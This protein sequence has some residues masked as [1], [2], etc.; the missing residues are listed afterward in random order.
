M[1][2]FRALSHADMATASCAAYAAARDVDRA[3][4]ADALACALGC[5]AASPS[6]RAPSEKARAAAVR[7]PRAGL[8]AVLGSAAAFSS[9][10]SIPAAGAGARAAELLQSWGLAPLGGGEHTS[11]ALLCASAVALASTVADGGVARARAVWELAGA[12]LP[13]HLG[14]WARGALTLSDGGADRRALSTLFTAGG[15]PSAITRYLH[16]L[17]QRAAESA[18]AP[19]ATLVDALNRATP[20]VHAAAEES[21]R[22]DSRALAAVAHALCVRADVICSSKT[23]SELTAMLPA[24][25]SV[26]ISD[27]CAGH[28]TAIV[29]SITDAFSEAPRNAQLNGIAQALSALSGWADGFTIV[30]ALGTNTFPAAPRTPSSIAH[31]IAAAGPL[32]W[33]LSVD[34]KPPNPRLLAPAG[35]A[36]R[37]DTELGA[38]VAVERAVAEALDALGACSSD[39]VARAAVCELLAPILRSLMGERL[40]SDE[41]ILGL[42]TGG[43]RLTVDGPTD[44]GSADEYDSPPPL[45]HALRTAVGMGPLPGAALLREPLGRIAQHIAI[46]PEILPGAPVEKWLEKLSAALSASTLAARLRA[47]AM[48]ERAAFLTANAPQYRANSYEDALRSCIIEVAR[49]TIQRCEFNFLSQS[50]LRPPNFDELTAAAA[51]AAPIKRMLDVLSSRGRVRVDGDDDASRAIRAFQT[52]LKEAVTHKGTAASFAHALRVILRE[53]GLATKGDEAEAVF[54]AIAA[55]LDVSKVPPTFLRSLKLEA[56]DFDFSSES[57]RGRLISRALEVDAVMGTPVLLLCLALPFATLSVLVARAIQDVAPTLAP[58]PLSS[59]SIFAPPPRLSFTPTVALSEWGSLAS[60]RGVGAVLEADGA[61]RVSSILDASAITV[62]VSADGSG[63]GMLVPPLEYELGSTLAIEL[64]PS[65]ERV[66]R[67]MVKAA[68]EMSSNV[69]H[70]CTALLDLALLTGGPIATLAIL[71]SEAHSTPFASLAARANFAMPP[72]LA[73]GRRAEVLRLITAA[74]ERVEKSSA[75]PSISAGWRALAI[76]LHLLPASEL[77][78]D[79]VRGRLPIADKAGRAAA[80]GAA[81]ALINWPWTANPPPPVLISLLCC[82]APL[83]VPSLLRARTRTVPSIFVDTL[84]R[85][86]HSQASSPFVPFTASLDFAVA[87]LALAGDGN[88]A[89]VLV[90]ARL[91]NSALLAGG[92]PEILLELAAGSGGSST[93]IALRETAQR[94]VT[95]YAQWSTVRDFLRESVRENSGRARGSG[96][97]TAG[98]EQAGRIALAALKAADAQLVEV[99]DYAEN[100]AALAEKTLADHANHAH[101]LDAD[102]PAATAVRS[103]APSPVGGWDTWVAD[104]GD[105]EQQGSSVE[106]ARA[107][108][109]ERIES[110]GGLGVMGGGGAATASGGLFAFATSALGSIAR[111]ASDPS[112][113]GAVARRAAEFVSSAAESADRAVAEAD[114]LTEGAVLSV[115]FEY[116]ERAAPPRAAA[117]DHSLP[118]SFDG[119][120]GWNND[121]DVPNAGISDPIRATLPTVDL[122]GSEGDYG[123]SDGWNNDEVFIL[124]NEASQLDQ[125]KSFR[126]TRAAIILQASARGFLA[127]C[128]ATTLRL[129]AADFN[130]LKVGR[131]NRER[132][133]FVAETAAREAEEAAERE[134]VR[135]AAEAAAAEAAS[136]AAET[137]AREA[138]EAAE[139]E[140]RARIS[141]KADEANCAAGVAHSTSSSAAAFFDV[142]KAD[143]ANCAAGV[144]HSTSSSAAAFF[145]VPISN[146]GWMDDGD[147][148]AGTSGTVAPDGWEVDDSDIVAGSSGTVAP[149]GWEVDDSLVPPEPQDGWAFGEDDIV[150]SPPQQVSARAPEPDSAKFS[151]APPPAPAPVSMEGWDSVDDDDYIFRTDTP[152]LHRRTGGGSA[153]EGARTDGPHAGGGVD[154]A[155]ARV[156]ERIERSGV[157][158]VNSG[159]ALGGIGISSLWSWGNSIMSKVDNAVSAL[160]AAADAAVKEA[161]E[162]EARDRRREAHQ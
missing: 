105:A 17:S 114:K 75:S 24:F 138:E 77:G 26:W 19:L 89:E 76:A 131:V 154:E 93:L 137:A 34:K 20:T 8:S 102:A 125:N 119:E 153:A 23:S 42:S 13:G 145:D 87:A 130:R 91:S 152:A 32:A 70:A 69:A 99:S 10:R 36:L 117:S 11:A 38:W 94:S 146:S 73:R 124:G 108:V 51:A 83:L 104:S 64:A 126:E 48:F 95:E 46:H 7:S 160:A 90:G 112:T 139:R 128:A 155:R 148:A 35:D 140:Q 53:A 110:I 60:S 109:L 158:D 96:G 65:W 121:E 18:D 85:T 147:I 118:L 113:L 22:A 1:S 144:A 2:L 135:I 6:A 27:E 12:A 162:A 122:P 40:L 134:R 98:W 103:T 44:G 21:E 59:S 57:A 88:S 29:S 101:D 3:A 141:V 16:A 39:S 66:M 28:A 71:G 9:S 72:P 136:A 30:R 50:Q 55:V 156:L 142:P 127:R 5:T 133:G 47:S 63:G 49:A 100:V 151:C 97:R 116:T 25:V 43:V 132:G 56:L 115:A 45:F 15:S 86:L 120:D 52:A 79:E 149:D 123:G 74:S 62:E 106:E 67:A 41:D 81:T 80:H 78:G 54:Q 61:P 107:R 129:D 68:E 4:A 37:S 143:E 33:L 82:A 161:E 150:G 31:I 92:F 111:M 84:V 14:A 159:S 58:N 157:S